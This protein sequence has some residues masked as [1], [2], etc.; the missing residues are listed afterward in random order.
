MWLRFEE[1][2]VNDKGG[3]YSLGYM[4]LQQGMSDVFSLLGFCEIAKRF[5]KILVFNREWFAQKLDM[6]HDMVSNRNI[7]LLFDILGRS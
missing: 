7:S 5:F 2:E 1:N 3:G 4:Q 6:L